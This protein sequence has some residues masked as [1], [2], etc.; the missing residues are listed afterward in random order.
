MLYSS[1]QEAEICHHVISPQ[2][3]KETPFHLFFEI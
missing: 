1:Q 2:L 3:L